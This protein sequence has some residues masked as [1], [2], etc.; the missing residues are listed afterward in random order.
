MRVY[1]ARGLILAALLTGN[2]PADTLLVANKSDASV[3]L[4]DLDS[5]KSRATLPTGDGPHEIAVSGDGKTAVIS[6]YGSR[7]IPGSTLTVVE[8]PVF[9]E[10]PRPNMRERGAKVEG[11]GSS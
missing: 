1:L 7:D 4:L 6:N 5:G 2:V 8:A 10:L 9:S 11:A 3:D